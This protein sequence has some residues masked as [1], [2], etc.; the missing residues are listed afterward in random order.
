MSILFNAMLVMSNAMSVILCT[1]LVDIS[2]DVL[3]I[4]QDVP[5]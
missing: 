2:G 1:I 3:L 5:L 4:H